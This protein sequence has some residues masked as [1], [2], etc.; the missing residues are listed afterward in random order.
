MHK[1]ILCQCLLLSQLV[2]SSLAIASF[3]NQFPSTHY[4]PCSGFHRDCYPG[5]ESCHSRRVCLL[6]A[7]I[8]L[9]VALFG[10]LSL[11]AVLLI[12]YFLLFRRGRWMIAGIVTL[13]LASFLLALAVLI[14]LAY[15][16]PQ[17]QLQPQSM[18]KAE[19]N[20]ADIS[21]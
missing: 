15:H 18:T 16:Q 13:T 1:V 4:V 3:R 7:W 14:T 6:N 17:E 5:F 9:A 20:E 21:L 2:K 19:D 11:L 8:L 12:F 10:T